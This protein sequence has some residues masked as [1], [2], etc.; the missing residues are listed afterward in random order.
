VKGLN[1][2]SNCQQFLNKYVLN[3]IKLEINI[4]MYSMI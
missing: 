4:G 1:A 3:D 2:N